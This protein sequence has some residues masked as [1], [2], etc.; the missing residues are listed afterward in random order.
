MRK[1]LIVANWKMNH[2]TKEGLSFLAGLQYEIKSPP[3]GDIVI[4]PPFTTLYP[5]SEAFDET[6]Y[7]LGAQNMHWEESGAFTGEISPS[8]LCDL[9][10]RYVLIGHSERRQYFNETD[11]TVN[12]KVISATLK[13][14]FPIICIGESE[15][16][17]SVAKTFEVLNRQMS[18]ALTEVGKETLKSITWAYEPIWAIG[19]GKRASV[20]QA[21]EVAFWIRTFISKNC[22]GSIANVQRILYGGSVSAET[23]G[24]FMV[25]PDIDGLLVGGAS[26]D[27]KQFSEIITASEQRALI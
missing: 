7:L 21:Q 5:L 20:E 14:L 10:I 23:A 27:P 19:T 8:F 24:D 1:K 25:Q 26:L 15:Q 2:S 4:C 17:R 12:K 22:D 11:E 9:G 18:R 6:P 16:E 13:R 3:R